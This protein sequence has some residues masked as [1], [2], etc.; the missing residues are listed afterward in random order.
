MNDA[1]FEYLEN[2]V[3]RFMAGE[4]T[5]MAHLRAL[6]EELRQI[7]EEIARSRCA[8]RTWDEI[9]DEAILAHPEAQAEEWVSNS[10]EDKA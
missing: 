9:P 3:K 4:P 10:E 1:D 7:R 2:R 8:C 6:Q 5:Y